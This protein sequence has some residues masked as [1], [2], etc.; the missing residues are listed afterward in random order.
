VIILDTNV[1]SELMRPAPSAQVFDWV[2][3]NSVHGLFTTAITQAEIYYGLATSP[4]GKK[5]WELERAAT[6]VFDKLFGERILPFDHTA[7][8]FF[9]AIAA[10]RRALGRQIGQ[11]DCQIAAIAWTYDAAVVTRDMDGFADCGVKLIDPWAYSN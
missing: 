4:L 3:T 6:R 1:V 7:V 10:K 8:P 5:R 11:F 2:A 9:A